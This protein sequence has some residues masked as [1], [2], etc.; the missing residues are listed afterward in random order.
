M[1]NPCL[2]HSCS[3]CC[4]RTEMTLTNEDIER[5]SALG[6]SDFYIYVNGYL[7]LKNVQGHCFFLKQDLCEINDNKPAG[8][9]LYP[10][11]MDID[12]G[13]LFLHDY[14]PY[15]DEFEFSEEDGDTLKELIEREET[16]RD[17]RILKRLHELTG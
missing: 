17:E 14:C 11:I 8:C 4:Y 10:L 9:R 16:E 15:N 7:Q 3:R 5:I 6:Y 12:T 2:N 1:T 13:E